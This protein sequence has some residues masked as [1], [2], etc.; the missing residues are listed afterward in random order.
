MR[1]EL[2]SASVKT[3]LVQLVIVEWAWTYWGRAWTYWG[4]AW[5]YWDRA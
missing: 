2:E 5:T 3:S 4:R 1:V